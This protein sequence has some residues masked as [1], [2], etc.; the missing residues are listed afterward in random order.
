MAMM[1]AVFMTGAVMME[2]GEKE[3]HFIAKEVF[4]KEDKEEVCVIYIYPCCDFIGAYIANQLNS[5]LSTDHVFL[6]MYIY[7][8]YQVVNINWRLRERVKTSN[9]GLVLCLNLGTDPPDVVK[10]RPC[11]RQVRI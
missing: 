8:P 7:D 1:T 5:L 3:V 11:S 4:E 6:P 10:T 9:V 2:D